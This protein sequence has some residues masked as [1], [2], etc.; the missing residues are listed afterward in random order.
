MHV[1]NFV[2][3]GVNQSVSSAWIVATTNAGFEEEVRS[4]HF[5]VDGGRVLDVVLYLILVQG[6]AFEV[7]GVVGVVR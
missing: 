6:K 4:G 5:P 1:W 2:E 7:V 3:R